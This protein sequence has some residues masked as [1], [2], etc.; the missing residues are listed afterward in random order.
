MCQ[1]V[2]APDTESAYETSSLRHAPGYLV[3]S[4]PYC[5]LNWYGRAAEASHLPSFFTN[6]QITW[7]G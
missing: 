6:T 3:T 4:R 1:S 5:L 7:C 2:P